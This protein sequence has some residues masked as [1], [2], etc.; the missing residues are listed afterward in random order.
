VIIVTSIVGKMTKLLGNLRRDLRFG[1]TFLGGTIPSRYADQGAVETANTD[2]RVL[3]ILFSRVELRPNDVVVDVGCGKGRVLNFLLGLSG[4]NRIV[5][6]ELDP[7]IAARTRRR[8]RKYDRVRIISGDAR[9]MIPPDGT[10]FYLYHPFNDVVLRD[11]LPRF[12]AVT[13]PGRPVII[14]YNPVH[15]NL[16][17]DDP[18]WRVENVDMSGFDHEAAIIRPAAAGDRI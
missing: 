6:L 2:Y 15:L 4:G 17:A 12:K 10:I 3:E 9:T 8:L 16:F 1:G 14:Y 5:G 11:V 7:A 18:H 13:A